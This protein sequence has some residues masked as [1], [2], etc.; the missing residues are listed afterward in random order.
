MKPMIMQI[1]CSILQHNYAIAAVKIFIL[2]LPCDAV[3]GADYLSVH[4]TPVF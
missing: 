4:H 2:F 3:H 1:Q